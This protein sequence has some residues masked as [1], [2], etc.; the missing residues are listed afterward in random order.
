MAFAI[1][2]RSR[3][4]RV[5]RFMS[6]TH[7]WYCPRG[8]RFQRAIELSPHATALTGICCYL[9][10]WPIEEAIL[11]RDSIGARIHCR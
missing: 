10:V 7:Y 2:I 3:R 9:I 5:A 11:K 1:A 4:R 6:G 8:T